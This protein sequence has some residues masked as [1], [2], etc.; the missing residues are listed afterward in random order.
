[1]QI[2]YIS[3]YYSFLVLYIIF[4]MTAQQLGMN[5]LNNPVLE[6]QNINRRF[7]AHR[8]GC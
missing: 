6:E 3:I 1:M 7:E 8:T 4:A 2:N 5:K